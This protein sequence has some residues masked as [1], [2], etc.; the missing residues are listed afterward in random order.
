LLVSEAELARLREQVEARGDEW[1]AAAV[2]EARR[3]Y[4]RLRM[5][6]PSAEISFQLATRP[7]R[8]ARL[9]T[10]QVFAATVAIKDRQ[11]RD[12]ALTVSAILMVESAPPVGEEPVVWLL[13]TSLPVTTPAEIETVIQYYL[14]R[15]MIELFFKVLKSGCHVEEVCLRTRERLLNYVALYALISWRLLLVT[16]LA[17][18]C[19]DV[20]CTV[21]FS[22]DE[23]QAVYQMVHHRRP[24]A[25]P[26]TL[27]EMTHAVARLGGFLG[28]TGDGEPGMKA[29]WIGLNRMADFASAYEMFRVLPAKNQRR[30]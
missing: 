7:G 19:P 11:H 4:T 2:K 30:T 21:V 8:E 24:P 23:W 13:I 3:L 28:R 25:D 6:D 15:W 5:Q 1:N 27:R 17:R 10:Q 29:M 26:P 18:E 20:P 16:R 12:A 9:V 22:P 14:S